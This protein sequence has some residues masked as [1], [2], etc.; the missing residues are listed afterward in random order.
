MDNYRFDKNKWIKLGQSG[1]PE[2]IDHDSVMDTGRKKIVLFGGKTPDP[3]NKVFGDTWE[4]DGKSW[5]QI[6]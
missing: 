6:K 1:L 3:E 2:R 5:K 4:W